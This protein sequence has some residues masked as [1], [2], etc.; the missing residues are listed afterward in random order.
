MVD[1][2]KGRMDGWMDGHTINIFLCQNKIKKEMI[3]HSVFYIT[4][5]G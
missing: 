5:A 1:G 2:W 4:Y 3:T